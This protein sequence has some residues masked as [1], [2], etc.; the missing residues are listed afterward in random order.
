M[1]TFK[2]ILRRSNGH[3]V[4]EFQ[5]GVASENLLSPHFQGW[6]GCGPQISIFKKAYKFEIYTCEFLNFGIGN[7]VP[8]LE[9][10]N[11]DKTPSVLNLEIVL[12]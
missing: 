10:A 7:R 5:I 2:E 6:D 8:L 9:V 1:S 3:K 4:E 12:K 11:K